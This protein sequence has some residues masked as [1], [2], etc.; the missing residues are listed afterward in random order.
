MSPVLVHDFGEDAPILQR[1]QNVVS[2][3]KSQG[4]CNF[5]RHTQG[6]QQAKP[7]LGLAWLGLGLIKLKPSQAKPPSRLVRL[8]YLLGP[9]Y[10]QVNAPPTTPVRAP[11]PLK[12]NKIITYVSRYVPTV[13]VREYLFNS[14][15]ANYQI[16]HL[17]E[18][19]EKRKG[20]R[21]FRGFN[22]PKK[23]SC[24]WPWPAR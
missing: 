18:R 1:F 16:G 10:Y 6:S 15:S 14:T 7:S 13:M 5:G 3:L 11:S 19:N 17:T 2:F 21:G 24:A 12:R 23:Y 9:P 22:N 8:G 20:F 4:P